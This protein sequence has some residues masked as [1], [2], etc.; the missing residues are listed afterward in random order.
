MSKKRKLVYLDME[1]GGLNGLLENGLRGS[2]F[3]PILEICAY[4]TDTVDEPIVSDQTPRFHV[5]VHVSEAEI[6]NMD[7]WALEQHTNSGLL[8][9]CRVSDI[10]LAKAESDFID[11]LIDHDVRPFD[12][13]NPEDSGVLVGN[14]IGFDRS[15]IIDQMD[16]LNSFLHYQ[17]V[18][19]SGL[20]HVFPEV[21]RYQKSHMHTADS[22]ILESAGELQYY[23]N[24]LLM[25]GG[26]LGC[27]SEC[28]CGV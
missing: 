1:T 13:E 26:C 14:S 9:K 27:G 25:G 3:Y 6:E 17:M 18:D 23:R 21:P 15:Y 5:A 12:R 2:E 22:D 19:V 11:F 28:G 20:R 24:Q 10:D 16:R 8:S 7:P 4:I